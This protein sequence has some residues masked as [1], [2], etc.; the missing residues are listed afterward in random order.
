MSNVKSELLVLMIVILGIGMSFAGDGQID[1]A[2]LPYVINN[3]GSYVVTKDLEFPTSGT[4]GIIINVGNVSVDLNGHTLIGPGKTSGIAISGIA[5]AVPIK[6]IVIRNGRIC[7]WGSDGIFA[8]YASNSQFESLC[9]YNNGSHGIYAG[10][11]SKITGNTCA[12]NGGDGM[13][14]GSGTVIGNTCNLN[15]GNG[16]FVSTSSTIVNNV[17]TGNTGIG[18]SGGYGSTIIG[19][20]SYENQSHGIYSNS[21]SV[22][23]ENNCK[24]NYGNGIK[25]GAACLVTENVSAL[26]GSGS[27]DGAGIEAVSAGNTIEHNLVYFNDRGIDCN[28]A[29]GNFIAGNRAKNNTT[30]YD[31]VAGN[32]WGQIV[33]MTAG[34]QISTTDPYANFRY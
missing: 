8:Y 11:S 10:Y 5:A 17:C 27:Y 1:I 31:I 19:N 33:D 14:L 32:V 29:T 24:G 26:N 18:I 34:G 23:R 3:H 16:I 25:V 2:Y 21:N 6:N 9:C 28:P 30:D 20:S 13:Y 15:G 12:S 22:L 4:G 7:D